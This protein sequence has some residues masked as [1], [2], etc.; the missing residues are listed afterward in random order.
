M[1]P[2]LLLVGLLLA[3]CA[4]PVSK[5]LLARADYGAP[6]AT[7]EHDIRMMF[8]SYLKDP[9]TAVYRFGQPYKGYITKPPIRG[10]G[11]E[12]FGWIVEVDVNAKNGLGGYTGYQRY[13][14]FYRDGQWRDVSAAN[15]L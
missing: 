13:R 10:G 4:T 12:A 7:A 14:F 6:P 1:K 3:G 11:V 15:R 5:D 8:E 2:M 9:Y